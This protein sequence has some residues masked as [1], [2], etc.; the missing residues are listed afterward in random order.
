MATASETATGFALRVQRPLPARLGNGILRFIRTKPLGA[1]G[2]FLILLAILTA[3]FAPAIAPYGYSEQQL[4]KRLRDPSPDHWLGTD[5]LGRD[6][7]TRI[8]YGSRVS[9]TIGFGAV[10]LSTILATLVGLTTGYFGGKFDTIFQRVV[11]VWIAFPGLILLLFLIAIFGQGRFQIV[12]AIGLLSAAGGSRIIRSAAISVSHNQY[13]DA[14]RCIGAGHL[15]ILL[16]YILPNIV[17]I[18]L[19][20]ATIGLGAAILAESSLSFLGFGVLPPFPTWGRMLSSEGREFMT[21]APLLA[22]WP[23][24]A[25]TL[26]VFGFNVLGDALR[27]VLDPRMRG[28]R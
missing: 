28:S 17:H 14:A 5:H 20:S 7:F 24:L 2:A 16:V 11:D 4:S 22:V 18:M 1:I 23:G 12:L 9:V 26:T 25:I 13:V 6:I 10:A 21:Q 15:R 19:V 3:A 8:V 27:D